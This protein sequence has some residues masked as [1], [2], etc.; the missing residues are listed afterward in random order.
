LLRRQGIAALRVPAFRAKYG[1]EHAKEFDYIG[2][3]HSLDDYIR[4]HAERI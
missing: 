3:D 4:T 1:L 2:P